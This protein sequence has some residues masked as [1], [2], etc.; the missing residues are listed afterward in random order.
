MHRG[1]GLVVCIDDLPKE[2]EQDRN[3]VLPEVIDQC[4]YKDRL[5]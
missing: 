4:G 2:K 5:A 1:D 3:S